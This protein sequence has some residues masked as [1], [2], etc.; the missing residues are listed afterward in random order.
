MIEEYQ[1]SSD[2]DSGQP[3]K[4]TRASRS[5]ALNVGDSVGAR[6]LV[7]VDAGASPGV[8]WHDEALR[9][10][11]RPRCFENA[12]LSSLSSFPSSPLSSDTGK[13]SLSRGDAGLPVERR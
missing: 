5:A 9:L 3:E 6:S 13:A 11:G 7:S 2:S 12:A 4:G 10:P 8:T 1:G